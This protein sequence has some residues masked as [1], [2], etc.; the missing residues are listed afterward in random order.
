[1]I[2]RCEVTACPI[3]PVA[4]TRFASPSS[5]AGESSVRPSR[6]RAGRLP[7]LARA[8]CY[9]MAVVAALRGIPT[10]LLA[11]KGLNHAR[12]DRR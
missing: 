6:R 2:Q 11:R 3:T 8:L 9:R 12:D 7:A 5:G 4:P 1:M 10:P